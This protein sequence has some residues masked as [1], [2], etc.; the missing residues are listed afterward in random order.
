M[1]EFWYDHV[2]PKYGENVKRCYIDTDRFIVHAKT[3][4]IYKDIAKDVE[5]RLDTSNFE[6]DRPL[7]KVKNKNVIDLM[8]DEL[9]GQIMKEFVGL[10]S[11]IYSYLKDN[12]EEDKK[13]KRDKKVCHKKKI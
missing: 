13:R 6:L 2:K 4:D 7:P 1:Y 10:K 8:K 9:D 11:K 12:N 5:T 3:E